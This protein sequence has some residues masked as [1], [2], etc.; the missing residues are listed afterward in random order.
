VVRLGHWGGRW[1]VDGSHDRPRPAGDPRVHPVRIVFAGSPAAALP[2]LTRLL[3]GPH[4]V[5]AVLTR[6]DAPAGRGRGSR[7]SPVGVL[8]SE[9]G[10]ETLAPATSRDPATLARLTDLA[11]DAGAVVAYGGLLPDPVLA[12][13]ARGWVNLHFSLL[14]RWRGAAPVQHTLM[15]GDEEA[16]ATVFELVAEL[17]AGPV[18]STLRRPLTGD[19]TT[20]T[21]LAELA[22]SGAALLAH[23]L[24]EIAAGLRSPVPQPAAG[25]TRAPKVTVADAEVD[26]SQP[27]SVIDR[28]IRAC[29]PAPGAWTSLRGS[30][31]KLGPLL[32]PQSPVDVVAPGRLV[33]E[34]RRVLVGTGDSPLQLGSVQGAGKRPL[35][36]ADWARGQ[37]LDDGEAFI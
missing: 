31:V 27:S 30:R 2:S 18:W 16:G 36:A 8:A 1:R 37:H 32:R 21:L 17:D 10:V 26:W 20:G 28:R 11:P 12:T 35:P 5:V 9:R 7:P 29:T 13:A 25:M 15:A 34:R 22:E 14:P 33:V 24:D 19:E 3:D 23:T 4:E 6:P